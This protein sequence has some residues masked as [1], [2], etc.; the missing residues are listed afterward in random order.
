MV[1]NG[2]MVLPELVRG[3][4]GEAGVWP[5]CVVVLPPRFERG[6]GLTPGAGEP[7]PVLGVL[8]NGNF[9]L[10]GHGRFRL[11]QATTCTLVR[12]APFSVV[13]GQARNTVTKAVRRGFWRYGTLKRCVTTRN[14]GRRRNGW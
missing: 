14:E 1:V 13:A 7:V 5:E 6:F 8:R 9:R 10:L 12:A 3:Q 2:W 4:V 11:A